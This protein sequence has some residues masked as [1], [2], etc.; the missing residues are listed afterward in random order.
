MKVGAASQQSLIKWPRTARVRSEENPGHMDT[1]GSRN[2]LKRAR[3]RAGSSKPREKGDSEGGEGE[4]EQK[5]KEK[6]KVL[7][8]TSEKGETCTRNNG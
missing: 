1:R 6:Y 4:R 7:K 8:L 2:S 3:R 5:H